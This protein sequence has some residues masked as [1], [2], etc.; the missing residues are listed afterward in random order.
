MSEFKIEKGIP[1]PPKAQRGGNS[2]GRLGIYPW[3]E[4][5][6]GDSF[7]IPAGSR[8]EAR[9]IQLRVG[10]AAKN[11]WTNHGRVITT[12]TMEGGVRVW[13]VE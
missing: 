4:M 13:R 7:F 5:E 11:Q 3:K 6:V 8:G 2:A 12:R 1:I 9:V 10:S